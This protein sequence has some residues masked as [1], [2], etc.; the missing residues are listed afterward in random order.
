ELRGIVGEGGSR[1]RAVLDEGD[2]FALLLHRHHDVEP[3]GARLGDRRLQL[4]IEYLEHAAP[5]RAGLVPA[6]TEIA[7]QVPELHEAAEV[8]VMVV[9]G[10]YEEQKALG[11]TALD[12]EERAAA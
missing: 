4:R 9:I 7:H 10:K 1:D 5:L 2:G 6:E 12:R 3:G 8:V 11:L